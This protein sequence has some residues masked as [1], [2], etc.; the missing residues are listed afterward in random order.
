M[1]KTAALL[2]VTKATSQARRHVDK[3][4]P[5]VLAT[6][7]SKLSHDLDADTRLVVT[8]VTFPDGHLD[9]VALGTA[10]RALPGVISARAERARI[11]VTRVA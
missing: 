2:S 11:V 7:E 5:G 4:M 9:R 1:T 3:L 6:V 8:T 10:L